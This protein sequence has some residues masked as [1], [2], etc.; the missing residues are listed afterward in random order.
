MPGHSHKPYIDVL[1]VVMARLGGSAWA[2]H[3]CHAWRSIG[4]W[5]GRLSNQAVQ[6]YEGL[7]GLLSSWVFLGAYPR[8]QPRFQ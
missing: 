4:N 6:G 1:V 5:A 8:P 3:I 2:P 7:L